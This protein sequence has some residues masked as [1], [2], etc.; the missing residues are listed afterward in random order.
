[1]DQRLLLSPDGGTTTQSSTTAPFFVYTANDANDVAYA[2]TYSWAG[3]GSGYLFK[4]GD[5]FGSSGS[6]TIV[7]SIPIDA[8]PST[9]V[10]DLVSNR[11]FFTDS[12]GRIDY[13][14]DNGSTPTVVYGAIVAQNATSE[15]PVT[16][17]S[18]N[19]MV[20]ACFNSNGSNSIVVQA[21]TSLAWTTTVPAGAPGTFY[22]GPYGPEFNHAW[23]TGSGTP[24]MYV[25]GTGTGALPTLYSFG[26]NG[27]G[28]LN[29]TDIS[30]ALLATGSGDASPLTEFYN[31]LLL[32]DYLFVGVTDH[33]VATAGGG[34]AGCVLSLD[35]T[36]GFPTIN[37]SS[38]AL[39][40]PGGT[41]GIVVDNDSSLAEASSIYY[42][43][44]T[45]VTLVKATQSGLN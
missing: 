39:A 22:T 17:D 37:A 45:G 19:Q 16:I 43:T 32:K 29:P 38:P 35:I 36:N 14:I 25:A 33:C 6:P 24:V 13:L 40:A 11:V 27:S 20:Y 1:M 21:P 44:K 7:W 15:N 26:F 2:T 8:V 34:T 18:T 9:P 41:T 28:A 23:Y 5:V 30:S 12:N 4:I 31:A 42:A 10:Y 3:T